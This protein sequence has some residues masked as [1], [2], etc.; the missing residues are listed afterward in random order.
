MRTN[1]RRC[2]LRCG[3]AHDTANAV[4]HNR[5]RGHGMQS[6]P[7]VCRRPALCTDDRRCR[8]R[9]GWSCAKISGGPWKVCWA[10]P[11]RSTRRSLTFRT[12][13]AARGSPV[14]HARWTPPAAGGDG[15]A[16][17]PSCRNLARAQGSCRRHLHF[18][19]GRQ[20]DGWRIACVAQAI[21]PAALS[22]WL[23]SRLDKRFF[24][25][26]LQNSRERP[27]VPAQGVASVCR[28]WGKYGQSRSD[29][30]RR[31]H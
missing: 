14:R 23:F 22:A 11:P 10:W 5:A 15:P 4:A 13:V 6:G 31:G 8:L 29:I 19:S 3:D 1:D 25:S 7:A 16:H 26:L 28:P 24:A 9:S 20:H 12:I 2:R 17:R 30:G 21:T 27:E 18:P